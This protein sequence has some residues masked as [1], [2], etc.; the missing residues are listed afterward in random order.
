M[1]NDKKVSFETTRHVRKTCLCLHLQRAAR[2]IA[3]EFDEALQPFGL[4]NGQFSLL[5]AVNRPEAPRIGQVADTLAMDRTTLTAAVKP[6][7]RRGLL[8]IAPDPGDRRTRRL[9][10]TLEGHQKLLSALP[11]W[12]STHDAIERRMPDLEVDSLRT[13]LS[14]LA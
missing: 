3:R 11:L 4:T 7:V 13:D 12:Q 8:R 6:L 9:Y 10:L 1:S 14:G 5:M 2:A